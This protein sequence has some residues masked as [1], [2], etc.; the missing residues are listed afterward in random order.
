MKSKF[1]LFMFLVFNNYIMFKYF[2]IPQMFKYYNNMVYI[3][4]L[5]MLGFSYIIYKI[6]PSKID[7][8]IL[9]NKIVK[10]T[11]ILYF[12]LNGLVTIIFTIRILLNL[13]PDYSSYSIFCII[14]ILACIYLSTISACDICSLFTFYGLIYLVFLI[15]IIFSDIKLLNYSNLLPVNLKEFNNNYLM[16]LLLFFS[17]IDTYVYLFVFKESDKSTFFIA[18]IVWLLIMFLEVCNAIMIGGSYFFDYE[19]SGLLSHAI[20]QT[21]K[22]LGNMNFMLVYIVTL[23]GLF[24]LSLFLR[25]LKDVVKSNKVVYVY[26]LILFSSIFIYKKF[27]LFYTNLVF[28]YILLLTLYIPYFISIVRRRNVSGQLY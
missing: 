6:V 11:L 27:S 15:F 25:V 2:F 13:F 3:I 14:L 9:N 19:F 20:L 1:S 7:D 18:S 17:L 23:S 4:L 10:S 16:Y 5:I 22:F 12:C 8:N 24:K 21:F 26:S 28:I